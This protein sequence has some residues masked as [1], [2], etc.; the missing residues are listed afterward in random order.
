MPVI[1]IPMGSE[2]KQTQDNPQNSIRLKIPNTRFWITGIKEG[3]MWNAYIYDP[4]TNTSELIRK[5]ITTQNFSI[6]SNL[7]L[8]TPFPFIGKKQS[9]IKIIKKFIKKTIKTNGKHNKRISK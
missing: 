7:V 3:T 9:N 6:V 1:N 2:I 8:K 5:S 4:Q